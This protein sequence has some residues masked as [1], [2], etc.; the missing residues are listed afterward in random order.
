MST[1]EAFQY[2]AF[3]SGA[4]QSEVNTETGY[5]SAFQYNAFQED[6]FQTI[7]E[8]VEVI[9]EVVRGGGGIGHKKPE[10]CVLTIDG[11]DYRIRLE[12]LQNF[13][14]ENNKKEK[15]KYPKI[16][17]KKK[18]TKKAD[19]KTLYKPE[20]IVVK[21]VP[22]EYKAQTQASV[23]RTNEIL[24]KIWESNLTRLINEAE[25]EEALALV[26]MMEL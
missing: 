18:K 11:Q 24:R 23:D 4:F 8:Y 20:K 6:A 16:K 1:L 25:E 2:D 15:D 9:P 19:I 21:S 13:L 5:Q 10:L 14:E 12:N 3:Q 26:L 17:A 22:F 7:Y